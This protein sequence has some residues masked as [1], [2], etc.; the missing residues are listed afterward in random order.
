MRGDHGLQ[1]MA[2]LFVECVQG[3][4]EEPQGRR[5]HGDECKGGTL[6]LAG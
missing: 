2:T 4:V 6:S 1:T 5:A 3:L